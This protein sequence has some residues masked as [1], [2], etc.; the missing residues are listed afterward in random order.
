MYFLGAFE[1]PVVSYDKFPIVISKGAELE[2]SERRRL[3]NLLC[4]PV[5]ISR[6]ARND[7]EETLELP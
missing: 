2:Q 7:R 5:K 4:L 3:R 6:C 1:N